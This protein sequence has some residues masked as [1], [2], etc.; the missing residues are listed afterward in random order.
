MIGIRRFAAALHMDGAELVLHGH[1]HLNTTHW[2]DGKTGRVPVVGIA[3][4]SQIFG[5]RKP[6]SAYNL[7]E[8]GGEKGRWSLRKQR[9]SLNA[10][11]TGFAKDDEVVLTGQE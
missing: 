10:E 3:S 7:F 4:G 9:F 6:P 2:L 5:G 1:T 11:G 8:I